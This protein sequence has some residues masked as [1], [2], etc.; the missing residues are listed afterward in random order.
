M[1]WEVKTQRLRTDLWFDPLSRGC[2]L[3]CLMRVL[4]DS[5][6]ADWYAVHM[7][8]ICLLNTLSPLS[9][10]YLSFL[11]SIIIICCPS[12]NLAAVSNIFLD[13]C[14]NLASKFSLLLMRQRTARFFPALRCRFCQFVVLRNFRC[15]ITVHFVLHFLSRRLRSESTSSLC[16]QKVVAFECFRADMEYETHAGLKR[17]L[18]FKLIWVSVMRT[19][20]TVSLNNVIV[21]LFVLL[22][23]L[24]LRPLCL[25]RYGTVGP[26]GVMHTQARRCA[27][28]RGYVNP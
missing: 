13:T 9:T 10:F 18:V 28:V 15:K 4:T 5:L 16:C 1:C 27:C 11:S 22:I 25:C 12:T 26:L 17:I 2:W 8:L 7:R 3:L 6:S 24:R 14:N 23:L 21:V 19:C 20:R